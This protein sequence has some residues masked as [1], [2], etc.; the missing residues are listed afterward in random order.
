MQLTKMETNKYYVTGSVKKILDT[1]TG[2]CHFIKL[3]V[4]YE[5]KYME[6]NTLDAFK[7]LKGKDNNKILL[8]FY[9]SLWFSYKENHINN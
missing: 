3:M 4:F 1:A 8:N 6:K 9:K 2:F 5:T 7:W